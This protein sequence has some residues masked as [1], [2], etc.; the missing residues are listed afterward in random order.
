[1]SGSWACD[2][3]EG[4]GPGDVA[5]VAAYGGDV[6]SAAE[7]QGLD[8]DGICASVVDGW[9]RVV[10]TAGSLVIPILDARRSSSLRHRQVG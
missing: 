5:G 6:A 10:L 4:Q 3:E 7:T 1:M 2:A 9:C 8:G